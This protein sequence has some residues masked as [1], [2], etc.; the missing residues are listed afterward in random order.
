MRALNQILQ[1][2]VSARESNSSEDLRIVIVT[3]RAE[4]LEK[5]H[6]YLALMDAETEYHMSYFLLLNK[7]RVQDNEIRDQRGEAINPNEIEYQ[8]EVDS[9]N[10]FKVLGTE[11]SN[12]SQ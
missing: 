9:S 12:R 10:I 5:I 2:V 3:Q 8:F 6:Q 11:Q 4:L 7:V 1:N